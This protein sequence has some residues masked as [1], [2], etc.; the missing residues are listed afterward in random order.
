MERLCEKVS[1]NCNMTYTSFA[2]L[3]SYDCKENFTQGC[4]EQ[5]RLINELRENND[6]LSSNLDELQKSWVAILK[7]NH[8]GSDYASV[9]KY[10]MNNTNGVYIKEDLYNNLGTVIGKDFE[11][12]LSLNSIVLGKRLLGYTDH[13]ATAGLRLTLAVYSE[14]KSHEQAYHIVNQFVGYNWQLHKRFPNFGL[15]LCG[16][17]GIDIA[18]VTDLFHHKEKVD[19]INANQIN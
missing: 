5:V 15:G 12:E 3:A 9:S 8:G 7:H 19:A 1:Q 13:V 11:P 2:Q 4:M 14:T 16:Y 17:E 10:L 18:K 6:I